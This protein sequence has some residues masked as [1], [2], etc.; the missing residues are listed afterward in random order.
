MRVLRDIKK[1]KTQSIEELKRARRV[2]EPNNNDKQ[3]SPE[4]TT[5]KPREN[6]QNN[7]TSS[8]NSQTWATVAPRKRRK[9]SGEMSKRSSATQSELFTQ[10]SFDVLSN[11]FEDERMEESER[12]EN[13]R[14]DSESESNTDI[15]HRRKA[16][17]TTRKPEIQRPPPIH[18]WGKT[19]KE[20]ADLLSKV[21][22]ITEVTKKFE[23]KQ[24]RDT[25]YVNIFSTELEAFKI[26]KQI[27]TDQNIK[28]YTYIPK[29]EKPKSIVLK[30]IY[31]NFDEKDIEKD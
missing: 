17:T 27:L 21:D 9:T 24:P 16:R 8:G 5:Q 4:D 15:G 13:E 22:T 7:P 20:I 26:F 10:N 2:I 11:D 29:E 31:G 19:L 18:T 23:L 28:S 6:I 12:K 3:D 25:K 1:S 30:G 14:E